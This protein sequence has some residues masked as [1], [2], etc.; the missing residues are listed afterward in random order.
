MSTPPLAVDAL[1]WSVLV[2]G[3]CFLDSADCPTT[4]IQF[5]TTVISDGNCNR[6]APV[7]LLRSARR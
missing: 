7:P 6:T 5:S 4:S 3:Y 2:T 1:T